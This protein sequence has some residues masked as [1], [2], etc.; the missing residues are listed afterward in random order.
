MR[1]KKITYL[2]STQR[3]VWFLVFASARSDLKEK[4]RQKK[5]E[6]T[7]FKKKHTRERKKHVPRSRTTPD[8]SF[9]PVFLIVAGVRVAHN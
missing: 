6:N 1:R 9:G 8:A 5:E 4:T 2:G 3:V 7:Q